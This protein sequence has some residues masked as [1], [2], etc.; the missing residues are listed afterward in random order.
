MV[1]PALLPLMRTSRLPVDDWT[2]APVAWNGLVCFA[3]RLNLVSARVPSRFK[4]SRPSTQTEVITKILNKNCSENQRSPKKIIAILIFSFSD[5]VYNSSNINAVS[6]HTVICCIL[7]CLLYIVATCLVLIVLVVLCV[8]LSSY[9]YLLYCVC[10]AVF[11][12]RCRTAGW[13]PVSGRSCD[14]PHRHRYFSVSLCL[15]A[16]AEMVPKIPSCHYMLLT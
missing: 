8:L 14:R 13:K 16:N 15:K 5:Y 7:R 3:E 4:R 12:F 2:D 1:Y 6:K 11:Y 9:V 10:I